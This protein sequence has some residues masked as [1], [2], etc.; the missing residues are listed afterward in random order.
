MDGGLILIVVILILVFMLAIACMYASYKT[1]K[2]ILGII[3]KEFFSG[4]KNSH[5][6]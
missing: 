6:N 5:D 4:D 3:W 2:V 1:G